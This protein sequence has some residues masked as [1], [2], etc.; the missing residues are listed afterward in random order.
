[1]RHQVVEGPDGSV[2]IAFN[3]EISPEEPPSPPA[4]TIS[5]STDVVAVKYNKYIQ[6]SFDCFFLVSLFKLVYLFRIIDII[7]FIF[8]ILSTFAVHTELPISVAPILGHMVYAVTIA[9]VYCFISGWLDFAYLVTCI[10]LCSTSILTA[11][12]IRV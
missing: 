4:P 1:M 2:A 6:L 3:Q 10:I 12:K 11:E 7:N 5:R 8:I 9:P